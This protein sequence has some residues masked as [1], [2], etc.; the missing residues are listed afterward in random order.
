MSVKVKYN[1]KRSF[2][3]KL[4]KENTGEPKK[5][6]SKINPKWKQ[7]NDLYNEGG[8]GFNPHEKYL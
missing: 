1:W 6:C 3:E 2:F 5:T 7:Y 4:K 8:E